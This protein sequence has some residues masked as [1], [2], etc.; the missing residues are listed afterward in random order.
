M[1][2]RRRFDENP[3]PNLGDQ[4]SMADHFTRMLDQNEQNIECTAA[5]L[6][7]LIRLLEN[8]L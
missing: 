8:A 1:Y 2:A 6:D 5:E 3:G 7:R 4:L